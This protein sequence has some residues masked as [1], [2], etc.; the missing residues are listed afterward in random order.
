MPKFLQICID[1]SNITDIMGKTRKI[2]TLSGQ[3]ELKKMSAHVT[4]GVR[5]RAVIIIVV[6]M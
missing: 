3:M 4:D 1:I 6:K 5:N 2:F